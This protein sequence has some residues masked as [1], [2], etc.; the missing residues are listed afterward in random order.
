MR[1]FYL[2][3][4]P[5]P[6]LEKFWC[7]FPISFLVLPAT[8][9]L[10]QPLVLC[11]FLIYE[12]WFLLGSSART[13]FVGHY[14]QIPNRLISIDPYINKY[15]AVAGSSIGIHIY[16]VFVSKASGEMLTKYAGNTDLELWII[17]T[18]ENSAWPIMVISFV[19]LLVISA[20][21]AT[22][23]FIRRHFGRPEQTRAP[24]IREFHG[25]SSQLVKAMPS[26]I[27]TSVVEDNCTA[28]TCAICLED[29]SVGEKLRILPCHH[30]EYLGHH[31]N[32]QS[33]LFI[34]IA[35]KGPILFW[36]PT[37]IFSAIFFNTL[38]SYVDS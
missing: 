2:L 15:I 5:I 24:N 27:F 17:P 21:L 9:K 38:L 11:H 26:L 35:S 36:L 1:L 28:T 22:C 6:A 8:P 14:C 29:Y 30:S 20:V 33:F 25:M 3:H 16:A 4:F 7:Q 18:F 32:H 12:Y 10:C 23:F 19:A 37:S 31:L 34:I 13:W